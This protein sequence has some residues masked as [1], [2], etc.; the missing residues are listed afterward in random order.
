MNFRISTYQDQGHQW[1]Y[2]RT[3]KRVMD[4]ANLAPLISSVLGGLEGCLGAFRRARWFADVL[5]PLR[6]S[7]VLREIKDSRI[8]LKFK[9]GKRPY[10]RNAPSSN[11][12]I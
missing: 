1:A 3:L 2:L 11:T 12:G 9:E 8:E 10:H 5:V 4:I 7:Q 6:E